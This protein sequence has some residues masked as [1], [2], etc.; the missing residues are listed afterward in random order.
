MLIPKIIHFVWLGP[1]KLPE[2]VKT[3]QKHHIDW[4]IIVWNEEKI[5]HIHL[6]NK[7]I[8]ELPNKRYNQKSDIARLEILYRYGGVY[9]DSDIINIKNI[10]SLIK[11]TN[12]FFVQE[13]LGLLSNS[14][15]GSS[16]K[17]RTILKIIKHIKEKFDPNIAVWKS[18][19]PKII[20]DFLIE[21]RKI[22]IPKSHSKYDIE[23]RSTS[24][25]IY[26]YYYFNFMSTVI[27]QCRDRL[28]TDELLESIEVNKDLK[29]IKYNDVNIDS[30][31][32]IQL[33]MGGKNVNYSRVLDIS[34]IRKNIH[35]YFNTVLL[36][37]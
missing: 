34:I 20:T 12:L 3:W 2:S 17:N 5:S 29:Y 16:K 10:D 26:P 11:D 30:I 21:D 23:S 13:K 6:I 14:I 32:G 36:K 18:T 25:S 35:K 22:T 9:I 24:I 7:D 15:I 1:H 19:G 37:K 33:W 4:K 31:I 28:L 8:Y 27:K